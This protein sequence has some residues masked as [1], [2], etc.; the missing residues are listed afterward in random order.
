[1]R[2][3]RLAVLAVATLAAG[4]SACSALLDWSDFTG[5]E[6]DAGSDGG[7]QGDATMG[8]ARADAADSA[9]D[10]IVPCGNQAECAPAAPSGWTGPVVLYNGAGPA[11]ACNGGASSVFDGMG[12]LSAPPAICTMCSCGG[13][14]ASCAD[15]VMTLYDEPTCTSTATGTVTASASC[16]AIF[17][18]AV[19]VAAP[20]LTGSCPP[21]TSAPTVTPPS[22]GTVA[23]A[24]PVSGGS[25]C[26]GGAMCV[27]SPPA[28]NAVCVMQPGAATTCPAG[29]PDGP[30]IFYQ[31]VN[32]TRGCS[33]CACSAPSGAT[34]SIASPAIDAYQDPGC[35][36]P[37][38]NL[39]APS[40]C[41]ILGTDLFVELVAT[42]TLSGT[43]G[44]SVS[45]GGTATG[46]A[47]GTGATSFCCL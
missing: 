11:P 18:A 19:T 3:S 14:S 33:D 31:G 1:M 16:G 8:D 28:S 30:S 41:T 7:N 34:C 46:S 17:A 21:G 4:A 13:A 29:Y 26:S 5:G 38:V 27:P 25:G 43:P 15:P 22:W 6:L 47:T 36:S 40:G 9:A 10:A 44:C 2:P 23:R 24:C 39:S 20:A 35:G 45:D 42:P 37:Q 32:D 12:N